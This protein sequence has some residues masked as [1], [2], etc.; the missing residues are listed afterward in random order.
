MR[1]SVTARN[2]GPR[3]S[4]G[5]LLEMRKGRKKARMKLEMDSTV[6]GYGKI[7]RLQGATG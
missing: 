3:G 6:G 5:F 4:K 2:E 1:L 7:W